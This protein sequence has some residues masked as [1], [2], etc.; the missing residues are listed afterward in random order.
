MVPGEAL[1]HG[2]LAA[3]AAQQEPL[4]TLLEDEV[5]EV[6]PLLNAM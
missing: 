5:I 3:L 2:D 4:P 1:T 6:C